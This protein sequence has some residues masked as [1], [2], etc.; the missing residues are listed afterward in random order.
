MLE[1]ERM[2]R[3]Y[4]PEVYG[5]ALRLCGDK[6]L[7][8]DLCQ[9]TFLRA[10][11]ALPGFKG[12]C[13]L[14]AWLK[15]ICRNLF[16]SHLRRQGRVIPVAE[17][18]ETAG[19]GDPQEQ[20]LLRLTGERALAAALSLEEPYR[21]VFRLRFW[22]GLP[23]RDIGRMLGRGENW[24]CVAFHRARARIRERLEDEDGT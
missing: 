11:D 12:E 10:L 8:E 15:R 23:Y 17:V 9:E 24:A 16:Y 5:Y 20:A 21:S 14:P 2:Y 1:A 6:P 22:G 4:Y 18:P 13:P 19:G 7:A 3:A